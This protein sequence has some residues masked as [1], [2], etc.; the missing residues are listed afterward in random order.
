[1]EGVASSLPQLRVTVVTPRGRARDE[2]PDAAVKK[3]VAA[4]RKRADAAHDDA[5]RLV[6][7]ALV[8]AHFDFALRLRAH[9]GD[10]PAAKVRPVDRHVGLVPSLQTVEPESSH[11]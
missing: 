1:M 9:D 3:R 4:A 10:L 8:A 5:P 2:P 6:I 7:A 11:Q